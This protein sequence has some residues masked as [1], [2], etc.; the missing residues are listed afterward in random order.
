MKSHSQLQNLCGQHE[1]KCPSDTLQTNSRESALEAQAI[2]LYFCADGE[3]ADKHRRIVVPA[4][5]V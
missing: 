2:I 5:I 1:I 3:R 4:Y